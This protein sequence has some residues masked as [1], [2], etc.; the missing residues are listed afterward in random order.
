MYLPVR[1]ANLRDHQI[2]EVQLALGVLLHEKER[3]ECKNKKERKKEER[4]IKRRKL[5]DK[6]NWLTWRTGWTWT[7]WFTLKMKGKRAKWIGRWLMR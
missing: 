3:K 2:L 1:L 7:A 5:W 4:H 6:V